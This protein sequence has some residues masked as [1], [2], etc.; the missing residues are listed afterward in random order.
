MVKVSRKN[1]LK[2]VALSLSLL[3]FAG[4]GGGGST[5]K[6]EAAKNAAPATDKIVQ[7]KS[8]K[9]SDLEAA[10]KKE[11]KLKVYSITSR[12]TKAGAAFEKKYGIKVEATDMKD[13]ELIDKITSEVK[14]KADG[15][16]MVIAQDSGR[17]YGELLSTGYLQNYVPADLKAD[18][19]AANQSPLVFVYMNKV[20][21]YNNEN[22]KPCPITNLWQLTEPANKGKFFFKSP[23]QEGINANFLTMLTK[24]E[25]AD[26]LAKAYKDLYKKD[27][28]LTTKNAGYEWIKMAFS[29]GLVMGSSDTS[30][31]EALGVKGQGINNV[32]LLNYSKI[33]YAEKKNLA[34]GVG[35]KVAPFCGFYYPEYTLLVK[36][37]KHPAA[38]KLFIQ[39]ILTQEGYKFWQDDMGS[40]SGN[41]KL[42]VAKGD[43]PLTEW[44]KVMV[45]DDPKYIFENRA[46][47]EEFISKLI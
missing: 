9:A 8:E 10:A 45:G 29:N 12:V 37:C 40:Y 11:G 3:A 7:V 1:L 35:D 18:I 41:S 13:F 28:K 30:M 47:V 46:E 25:I 42:A 31:T 38:A 23:M 19:P 32:G 20:L 14:A 17:V 33:R 36:D 16:D 21:F 6:K 24:P 2:T 27:L 26:K 4:C 22:G 5:D 43:K 39:F 15:A 44:Q 34:I